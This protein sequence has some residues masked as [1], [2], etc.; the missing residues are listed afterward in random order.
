[1]GE[2]LRFHGSRLCSGGHTEL[3]AAGVGFELA[4][5]QSFKL[6]LAK[7]RDRP[8]RLPVAHV[9]LEDAQGIGGGDLSPV[10][11]ED[12][13]VSHGLD[14]VPSHMGCRINSCYD[15]G[16]ISHVETIA[17]RIKAARK[18]LGLNQVELAQR[19][20]V[21]QSTVSDI[22][23]GSLF[24]ADVLM[25]LAEALLK[26]PQYLMTGKEAPF[27]L[28]D[29]EARMLSAFRASQPKPAPAAAPT[30]I[31]TELIG[32]RQVS[33]PMSKKAASKRRVG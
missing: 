30:P 3:V 25:N 21:N 4:G 20:R 13:V 10:E 16:T 24:G 12:V 7:L 9:A 6:E 22:E 2:V 33:S 8:P 26:T 17:S 5:C 11:I 14:Y 1:M 29:T 31:K 19:L 28:S 18:A 23:N 27:E 32:T 15:E